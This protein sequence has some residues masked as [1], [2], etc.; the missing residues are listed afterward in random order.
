MLETVTFGSSFSQMC[1]HISTSTFS[2]TFKIL[3][4]LIKSLHTLLSSCEYKPSLYSSDKP[5]NPD[6]SLIT[7]AELL[8]TH[9]YPLWWLPCILIITYLSI[10]YAIRNLYFGIFKSFIWIIKGW[11]FSLTLP[12]RK[13]PTYINIPC[14]VWWLICYPCQYVTF[15]S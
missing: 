14:P 3:S 15:Y 1:K 9:W 5:A 10:F 8:L 11:G 2:G 12:N 6:I 7:C 13:W 4:I